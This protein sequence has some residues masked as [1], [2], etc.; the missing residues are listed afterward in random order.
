MT[1]GVD[2]PSRLRKDAARNRQLL[3]VAARQVFSEQGLD[4]PLDEIARRA[5]VGNATLYRRFPTREDLY[6]AV[7]ADLGEDIAE[8]GRRA[9]RTED[10]WTALTV[11]IEDLCAMFER[12]RG[13]SD[14]IESRMTQSPALIAIGED[15]DHVHRLVFQRAQADGHVRPDVSEEDFGLAMYAMHRTLPDSAA[16]APGAWRRHLAILLEAFRARPDNAELP[17]RSLTR[18]QMNEIT[19]RKHRARAD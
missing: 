18:E 12:D 4:A 1:L 15:C 16:V 11:Y 14:L 8:A 19:E 9:V 5:G 3:L 10:S 7:F 6:E 2:A 13:L 17:G